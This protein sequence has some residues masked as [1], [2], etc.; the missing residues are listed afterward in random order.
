MTGPAFVP[1]VSHIQLTVRDV[2]SAARWFADV[3]ELRPFTRGDIASGP[4]VALRHPAAGFVIGLHT[5]DGSRGPA[6]RG[7]VDHI[8]FAVADLAALR[9]WHARVTALGH[10][11]GE[12]FDEAL[13]HNSRITAPGGLVVE[14]TA[15]RER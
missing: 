13:S 1:G 2:P 8:A 6:G 11:P 3:L 14:L 7:P 15:P 5:D 4:Y 10:A 12:I 9:A